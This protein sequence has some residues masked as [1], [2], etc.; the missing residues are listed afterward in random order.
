MT[1]PSAARIVCRSPVPDHLVRSNASPRWTPTT[2][3]AR[4]SSG[5]S[6]RAGHDVAG[7]HAEEPARTGPDHAGRAVG[8]EQDRGRLVDPDP[9]H[10]ARPPVGDRARHEGQQPAL[11]LPLAEVRIGDRRRQM[12]HAQ[13]VPLERHLAVEGVQQ[14]SIRGDRVLLGREQEL[15]LDREPG[16]D[17][18]DGHAARDRVVDRVFDRGVLPDAHVVGLVAPGEE[19]A[20]GA[21]N[22]PRGR[23][24]PRTR[25]VS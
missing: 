2:S 16:A 9:A 17:P 15:A 3:I 19:D 25:R 13:H 24:G 5:Y 14:G 21:G 20:V 22:A 12:G 10:L 4:V 8:L 11:A 6:V 7:T 1:A 23:T 18:A